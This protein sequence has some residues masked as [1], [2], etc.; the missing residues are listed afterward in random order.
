MSYIFFFSIIIFPSF[1]TITNVS[2]DNPFQKNRCSFCQQKFFLTALEYESNIFCLNHTP[3]LADE[4][5][6]DVKL[7]VTLSTREVER[8][9]KKVARKFKLY[10]QLAQ[11][12]TLLQDI[13]KKPGMSPSNAL[14]I[15]PC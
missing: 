7:Y 15:F 14:L 9:A 10:D 8:Q 13:H 5:K 6:K 1:Q 4:K 2:A 3:A 12:V 11:S